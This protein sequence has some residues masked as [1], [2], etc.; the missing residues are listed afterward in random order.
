MS[1]DLSGCEE[2][3]IHLTDD[4]SIQESNFDTLKVANTESHAELTP[5]KALSILISPNPANDEL[6]PSNTP[7][8]PQIVEEPSVVVDLVPGENPV[9]QSTSNAAPSAPASQANRRQLARD[10]LT[11]IGQAASNFL[12]N[13]KSKSAMLK[14]GI[15][16]MGKLVSPA[17][18]NFYIHKWETY[19]EPILTQIDA[20]IDSALTSLSH[21][22]I[23]PEQTTTDLAV[24]STQVESKEAAV[25]SQPAPDRVSYALYWDQLKTCLMQSRWF[26]VVDD[27]LLQSV[28]LRLLAKRMVSPAELFFHTA[29]EVYLTSPSLD[30]FLRQLQVRM[31]AAWDERLRHPATVFFTTAAAVR[32]VV[33]AG[34]F[35]G[36]A[37]QLGKSKVSSVMQ[38]LVSRWEH[39]ITNADCVVDRWLPEY[40]AATA[41]PSADPANA[42]PASMAPLAAPQ[43]DVVEEKILSECVAPS[44]RPPSASVPVCVDESSELS[45]S[46]DSSESKKRRYSDVSHLACKVSRR[47]RQRLPAMP[48]IPTIPSLQ[49][50]QHLANNLKERLHAVSWFQHVDE[51]LLQN[52]L[53]SA[54]KNFMRPAEH[55]FHTSLQ[56]VSQHLNWTSVDDFVSALRTR[57]GSAWDERLM[58]PTLTFFSGWTESINSVRTSAV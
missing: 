38:E 17:V 56:V 45:D 37:I 18:T 46:S 19:G 50:I 3:V 25:E 10:T 58:Q 48:T 31:G 1:S 7:I 41:A 27:I 9:E 6:H 32:S 35:V 52:P 49:S 40:L 11:H 42:S 16:T 44:S 30:E 47:L 55:F 14:F 43:A 28:P 5:S 20:K 29:T 4:Q 21:L 36:G 57:L 26:H 39:I 2:P 23:S 15:E 34:R 53:L 13:T 54:L 24:Q 33:G 51:I 12:N 22:H 8:S